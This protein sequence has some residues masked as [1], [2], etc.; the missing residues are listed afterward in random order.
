M[1]ASTSG[2]LSSEDSVRDVAELEPTE[3]LRE[4]DEEQRELLGQMPEELVEEEL[5]DDDLPLEPVK[6]LTFKEP[7]WA[8]PEPQTI[9]E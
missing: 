1:A 7:Q 5:R 6:T 2:K 9:R 8:D 4:D 3:E